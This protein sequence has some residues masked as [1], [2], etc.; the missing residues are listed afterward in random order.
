MEELKCVSTAEALGHSLWDV[1]NHFYARTAH[2]DETRRQSKAARDAALAGGAFSFELQL[3][4]DRPRDPVVFAFPIRGPAGQIIGHGR[5]AR[6]VTHEREVDRLK[7]DF[8]SMVSREL[9]KC[10]LRNHP[11]R[12]LVRSCQARTDAPR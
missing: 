10:R 7:D 8:L 3:S 9:L 11:N 2:P 4:G 6:D 12:R 1:E 5:L